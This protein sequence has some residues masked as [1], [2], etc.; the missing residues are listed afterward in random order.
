M[1]IFE[2]HFELGRATGATGDFS[3]VA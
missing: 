2:V 3:I 1:T